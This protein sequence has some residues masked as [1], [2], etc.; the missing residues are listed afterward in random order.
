MALS[1]EPSRK[2]AYSDDLRWRIVWQRIVHDKPYIDIA[3]SLNISVGR[4]HNIWQKFE[5]TGDVSKKMPA[6]RE[7]MLD[8]HHEMLILG[9]LAVH[10]DMYLSELCLYIHSATGTLVSN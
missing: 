4:V 5:A 2:T 8:E 10:P 6:E 9:L 7:R 1:A 3:Q